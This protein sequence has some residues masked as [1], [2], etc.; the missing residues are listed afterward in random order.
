MFRTLALATTTLLA[1]IY[2]IASAQAAP[3]TNGD[4]EAGTDPGSST[5]LFAGSTAIT[6]WTIL[7]QNAD[8]L[9]TDVTY[10]GSLFPAQSGTRSVELT[11]KD[12]GGLQQT[13]DVVDGQQYRVSFYTTSEFDGDRRLRGMVQ[14]GVNLVSQDFV[15][16]NSGWVL[17][18]FSFIADGTSA[19][20][21]FLSLVNRQNRFNA[22]IDNVTIAAVPVPVAFPLMAFA[23]GALGVM[24]MRRRARGGD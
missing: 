1:S 7:D 22:A 5:E 11:G 15:A 10:I 20:L 19:T 13:F 9:D 17:Q 3:F 6:G 16:E 8:P 23:L 12:L 24:G 18:T 14:S 4:F 2:L 21:T